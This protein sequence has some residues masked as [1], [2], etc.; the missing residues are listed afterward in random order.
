V[1]VEPSQPRAP[2]ADRPQP[3]AWLR[4]L[5]V[6]LV[7]GG[8]FLGLALWGVPLAAL[9][10]AFA[11]MHWVYGL[12]LAAVVLVQYA[13]RA[14]RQQVM[15]RPVAP[16]LGFRDHLAIVAVGFFCVNVFPAR[17]GEAVRPLLFAERAGVP[18]GAGFALVLVERVLDLTALLLC[19]LGAL[20]WVELPDRTI[21]IAGR[22]LVAADLVRSGVSAVLVPVLVALLGLAVL[23]PAALRLGERVARALEARIAA[24]LLHRL[25][26][27][28]LRFGA[29]FVEGLHGLRS[30]ARLSAV[31][32]LTALLF[33]SMGLMVSAVAHAFDLADQIGFV[34]GMAVV[35]ITMLGIAL[36]APPGFAGVFE[37][38]ARAGLALF[39]VRGEEMAGVSLAFALVLHWWPFL[40]LC[41]LAGFF[42]W[43]DGLGIGRLFRFA[44]GPS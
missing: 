5:V 22:S 24:P 36:P 7:V 42:L 38:S 35:S 1:E 30:P 3:L 4:T 40:V 28:L 20:A 6:G 41:G 18:L 39:G 11:R 8:L 2:R 23:G 13:L 29:A 26:R 37:A 10:D 21:E 9:R 19:L 25:L 17:L 43:R 14:A 12:H 31:V 27:G 16:A 34:P 32:G 44:R 15:L 33:V